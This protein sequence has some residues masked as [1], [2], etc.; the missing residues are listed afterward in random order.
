MSTEVLFVSHASDQGTEAVIASVSRSLGAE[1]VAVLRPE[2]LSR[3]VWRHEVEPHGQT[4]T[5][6]RP[7]GGSGLDDGT[8][9]VVVNH[10]YHFPVPPAAK[11][12]LKDRDYAIAEF[13]GLVASW[14]LSLGRRLINPTGPHGRPGPANDLEWLLIAK[15][16]GLPVARNIRST[17]GSSLPRPVSGESL[18]QRGPWPGG[19]SGPMPA[20]LGPEL[21]GCETVF[22]AG[23]RS[24]GRLAARFGQQCAEAVTATGLRAAAWRF[25]ESEGGYRVAAIDPMPSIGTAEEVDA[26]AALVVQVARAGEAE[27]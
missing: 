19:A 18:V 22:V 21:E 6:I 26:F 25:V 8:L 7:P 3:C 27:R 16:H 20:S 12:S 14:L 17:A 9:R 5:S 10:A 13:D 23:E 1:T 24:T 15:A 11:A 4:K 2:L